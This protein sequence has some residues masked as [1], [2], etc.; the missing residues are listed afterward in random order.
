MAVYGYVRVSTIRQ[1]SEVKSL[2]VQHR[3]IDGYAIMHGLE[4]AR[5]FV[6]RGMS[7]SVPLGNRPHGRALLSHLEAG[8]VVITAK[9]D[10]MF[11]SARD[12]LDVLAQLEVRG[13]SLHMID[14]GGDVTGTGISELMFTILS[15]VAESER[16]QT[17]E[18]NADIKRDRRTRYP[19]LG[20]TLPFGWQKGEKGELVAHPEQQ[21]AVARMREL[22]KQGLSLRSVADQMVAAGV[23]I[24]HI[25]VK[26]ALNASQRV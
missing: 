21:R 10:R 2:D 13:V 5:T 24:S 4:V 20:G 3:T 23:R 19:Y 16:D 1:A 26:N 8:D 17:R 9:L 25:G 11:R 22:R 7:G 18:R 12:A 14:L 6:E 15:A